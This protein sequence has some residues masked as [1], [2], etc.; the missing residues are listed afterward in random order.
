MSTSLSLLKKGANL[1]MHDFRHLSNHLPCAGDPDQ[2][3]LGREKWREAFESHPNPGIRSFGPDFENA[4]EGSQFLAAIFGNSPF[5][6]RCLTQ[7]PEFAVALLTRDWDETFAETLESARNLLA[8]PGKTDDVKR[9]LRIL[10][11]RAA[12]TIAAA[13]IA[14]AWSVEKVTRALSD[15]A[16]AAIE[17][18][19][20]RLLMDTAETGA[21]EL[22][23]PDEPTRESGL[24]ILG[25][26]KLGSRELN[27]SSDVDLIILFD[28]EKIRTPDPDRLLNVMVRLT[29]NLVRFLDERTADGYVF[30][31]DLRLRPD[32]ASTPP[33]MSVMAAEVYYE[34]LGQNWERAAMIKALPVAGDIAAGTQFLD[35]LRPYIWR[36][37]LDFAAIQDIHS[38][39]RQIDAHR[40]GGKIS[41]AGHNVKLG[42]GGIREIEFFAQTQQLIWG[43]RQPELQISSTLETLGVLAGLDHVA[44]QTAHEMAESYRFLRRVE[45]RVQMVNDEQTHAVP[46]DPEGLRRLSLFLG[47]E[48]AE[49]FSSA[50][51]GHLRRVENHYA[52]LFEDAPDLSAEGKTEGNLVFT[53]SDSDPDTIRT[54]SGLGFK[55][56]GAVDSAVRGWHHGR[57]RAM[58]SA[59]A[60]EL[61]TELM[62]ILLAELAKN[63]DPD[64]TFRNFDSFL[65][66]L[67]AG[68]Q[69]FSMFYANPQLLELV[70]GIMGTAPRLAQHL[71]RRP[72]VLEGVLTG[73]FFDAPPPSDILL[74]ELNRRLERIGALEEALDVSRRWAHDR[75][76]QVGVQLL[77]GY[78]EPR[79]AAVAFS[80]IADTAL[81]GLF[82]VV[83]AEF[84]QKH[85]RFAD[86]GMLCMALGKL[87]A[88]EMTASS[89]LDLIF[90]YDVGPD[91][92][93]SDGPRPLA[94]SQYFARLSQRLI[95]AVTAQTAE[96]AFFEVDMR[97]RP[98]G[99]KG[100]IA[101]SLEAFVLYH[102]RDAWTWEHMALSRARVIFGPERLTERTA[103][104]IDETLTRKRDSDALL[105]D[106]ADM[107][108]R[109]DEEHHSDFIWEAKHHRGGL[110][111]IDFLA[112]YLQ[113]KHAEA[114]PRVLS[115]N[116]CG[117]LIA[118][119][120]N[121]FVEPA[122][123]NELIAALD[124]WQA[125]QGLL[126]LTIDG[127]FT[128]NREGEINEAIANRLAEVGGAEDFAALKEKLSITAERVHGVFRDLVETP[129]HAISEQE[130]V[131]PE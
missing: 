16:D 60:R 9:D 97:L 84:A 73:D 22:A 128:P 95:N 4:A 129:A 106:V 79:A 72:N 70:A 92:E 38:I 82:P 10:K 121:G 39:K 52:R 69:L 109:M 15:F 100:P 49:A 87:G 112:Q 117:A 78:L 1:D 83:E 12:L 58:K 125:V 8:S 126:R 23:D 37:Y 50:L 127:V 21:I 7:D 17:V 44:R 27:Y 76:F 71:S 108:R 116:T 120:D 25:L 46:A 104:V 103:E 54:L 61:L 20:T 91:A 45:H 81:R 98:S 36:K 77:R 94:P 122:L 40:G 62:P 55:D 57:Y 2:L 24:V 68:V 56:P 101:S 67:P 80:N 63:P 14:D 43:G 33:A 96:G 65:S 26:G 115:P 13:D 19:A 28:A 75:Q 53:G 11:R 74:T 30:R 5:L 131:D 85:G 32:P 88:R 51:G 123:A 18:A 102:E 124:L 90:V 29:R 34:S 89:D 93:A 107:R 47:F 42:R 119:R 111:D 86:S 48:D 6:T 113:L 118:L 110:V 64:A 59:R 66:A 105:K 3:Q 31:T 130:T 99:A 41:I 35:R 114:C